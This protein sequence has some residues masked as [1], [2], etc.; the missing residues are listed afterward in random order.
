MRSLA[1]ALVVVVLALS[2]SP[3]TGG[4][5][6]AHSL[7]ETPGSSPGIAV[8]GVDHGLW[9]VPPEAV[10]ADYANDG[11][12]LKVREGWV[13]VDVQVV[14]LSSTHPFELPPAVE[15]ADGLSVLARHVAGGAATRYDAVSRV[16]SWVARNI[17]YEL[18]R[19]A[20]Q[21]PEEVVERRSA[22]C[23]GIARLTVA[24]LDRLA[25]EAREVSGYV[26]SD[27]VVDSGGYHRWIEVLYPD[28]GWVFSDPLHSHHFVPA[29]YVRLDSET[30]DFGRVGPTEEGLFRDRRLPARDLYLHGPPGVLA[31]RNGSRQLAAALSVE[32]EPPRRA[33]LRLTGR[34]SSR[35]SEVN[36]RAATFVGLEP[37]TYRLEIDTGDGDSPIARAVQVHDRVR[38]DLL[39]RVPQR[40]LWRGLGGRAMPPGTRGER[41]QRSWR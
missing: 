7:W 26:F 37:G 25:I 28:V 35:T 39:L 23:T 21:A 20:S 5:P 38:T 29:N 6:G 8:E 27:D 32:L 18:D 41:A 40:E 15:P 22:Y 4:A 1:L 36:G 12:R 10:V 14:P 16:L 3:A 19:D 11:Y 30:L 17:R 2:G 33:W 34:G 9:R 24:L 31:R 13:Q